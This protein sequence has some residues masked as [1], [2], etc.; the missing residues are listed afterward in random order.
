[1]RRMIRWCYDKKY[2]SFGYTVCFIRVI[3]TG[4]VAGRR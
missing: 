3:A 4:W 1:M 2:H